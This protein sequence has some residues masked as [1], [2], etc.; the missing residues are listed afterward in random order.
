MSL[1]IAVCYKYKLNKNS[2]T[3]PTVFMPAPE[4]TQEA[5]QI[6]Q[7]RNLLAPINLHR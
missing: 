7:P 2:G 4:A 6:S 5:S 1:H 3:Y